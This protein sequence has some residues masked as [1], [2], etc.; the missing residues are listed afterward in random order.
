MIK[1]VQCKFRFNLS[2]L[3]ETIMSVNSFKGLISRLYTLLAYSDS[4]VYDSLKPLWERD[5]GVQFGPDNWTRI[6]DGIFPKCT[7]ISIHEQNFKF[8]HR[9][10]FTPVRLHKMFPGCSDL[11]FKCKTCKGTLFH[12]FW[13]RVLIQPFWKGVHSAIQE[14]TGK[15]FILSPSLFLLNDIPIDLLDSDF[16]PLITTLIFLAKKCILLKWST[17]QVPTISMWISQLSA[18]LPLEKLTYD[19]NHKQ[20]EFRRLWEPLQSFLLKF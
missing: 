7:S 6:C 15:H 2:E 13:S 4:S 1:T 18:F 14:I 17:P 20:D 16:K 8:F 19:L 11:C 10:Y 5:L 9:I 12:V 3:K